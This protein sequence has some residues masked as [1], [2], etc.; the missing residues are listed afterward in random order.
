MYLIL[1][2]P[3]LGKGYHGKQTAFFFERSWQE[4]FTFTCDLGAEEAGGRGVG[5][6]ELR[7]NL[8]PHHHLVLAFTWRQGVVFGNTAPVVL[9]GFVLFCVW[10]GAGGGVGREAGSRERWEGIFLLAKKGSM[11]DREDS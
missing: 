1:T 11:V 9:F 8:L 4:L 5:E 2:A 6:L 3:D 10:W 7:G